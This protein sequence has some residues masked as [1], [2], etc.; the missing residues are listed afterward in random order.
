LKIYDC[1]CGGGNL[2][3]GVEDRIKAKG[4][5]YTQTFGQDWNDALYTLAKIES[6]FRVNSKIEHENTLVVDKFDDDKFDVVIADP[7]Y[8]MDWKGFKKD[9]ENDKS[10]RFQYFPSVS[11]EF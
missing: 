9:I 1:T 11:V 4:H 10:G 2:L 6:R 7:P 3:F 8:G 5:Q